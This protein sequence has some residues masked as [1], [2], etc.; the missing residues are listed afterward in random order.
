MAAPSSSHCA[1][2]EEKAPVGPCCRVMQSAELR[3][4]VVIDVVLEAIDDDLVETVVS[5]PLPAP[6]VPERL[7][8]PPPQTRAVLHQTCAF[9]I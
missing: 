5:S 2:E 9:L 6:L 4:A 8:Q 1:P 3:A 7:A